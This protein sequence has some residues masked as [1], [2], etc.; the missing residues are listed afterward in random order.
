MTLL[1]SSNSFVSCALQLFEEFY[2][3]AGLKLNKS[4]TEASIMSNDGTLYADQNLGINWTDKPFKTWVSG[5]H[6]TV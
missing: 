6:S 2:R 1:R 3:Y 4:K 5:L